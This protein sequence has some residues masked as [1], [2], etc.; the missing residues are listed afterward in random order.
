M[1]KLKLIKIWRLIPQAT[2]HTSGNT[3]HKATAVELSAGLPPKS[4]AGLCFLFVSSCLTPCPHQLCQSVGL[5]QKL[6]C[7]DPYVFP[8]CRDSCSAFKM[9]ALDSY[10]GC[11]R[12]CAYTCRCVICCCCSLYTLSELVV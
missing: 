12:F 11:I 3:L 6:I 1:R 4:V 5:S 7:N 2:N 8:I 10:K 9:Y